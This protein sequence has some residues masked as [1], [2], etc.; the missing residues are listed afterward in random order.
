M[1]PK[2]YTNSNF[3]FDKDSRRSTSSFVF[4][5]GG[6]TVRRISVKQSCIIDSIIK[7]VLATSE[8]VKKV[9]WIRKFLKGLKVIPMTIQPMILFCDNSGV[10]V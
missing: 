5:F 9:I 3:Q 10:V 6:V 1:V 4:T 8:A 7:L 2:G